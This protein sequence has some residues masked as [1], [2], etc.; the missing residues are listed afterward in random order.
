MA[1]IAPGWQLDVGRESDW[2]WVKLRNL[3]Q[4][5]SG[6]SSLA[7]G[8]WEVLQQHAV[9]RLVLELDEIPVLYTRLI[10]Q[11]VLLHKRLCVHGGAM[12]LCGLSAHNQEVLHLCR[13]DDRFPPYTTREDALLGRSLSRQPR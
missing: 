13:L 4:N 3:D 9:Y 12:R 7:E 10:G 5:A 11:L 6:T 8:L 1:E 2:L